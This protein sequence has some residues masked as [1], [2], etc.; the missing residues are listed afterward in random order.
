MET[1]SALRAICAKPP[2]VELFLRHQKGS[3]LLDNN[4]NE[5]TVQYEYQIYD[6]PSA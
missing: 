6:W 3:L 4:G 1:F 2:Y 5:L